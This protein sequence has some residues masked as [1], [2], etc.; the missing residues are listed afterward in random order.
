MRCVSFMHLHESAYICSKVTS[1]IF[2]N[3]HDH[4]QGIY[5]Q[6]VRLVSMGEACG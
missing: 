3:I 1:I 2:V 4:I 6:A 5:G